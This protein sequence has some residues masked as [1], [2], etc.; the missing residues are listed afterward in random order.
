MGQIAALIP[1]AREVLWALFLSLRAIALR[2]I[3]DDQERSET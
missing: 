1:L 2:R 3:L